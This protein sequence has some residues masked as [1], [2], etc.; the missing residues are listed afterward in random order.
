M[1]PD[2]EFRLV[3]EEFLSFGFGKGGHFVRIASVAQDAVLIELHGAA[4]DD[5]VRQFFGD[6]PR[7]LNFT[8]QI[9]SIAE[10]LCHTPEEKKG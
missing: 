9:L 3:G 2:E 8:V 6:A 7:Q 10:P 1:I 4:V 5:H